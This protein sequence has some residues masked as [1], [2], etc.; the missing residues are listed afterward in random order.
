MERVVKCLPSLKELCSFNGL[1][2]LKNYGG[3]FQTFQS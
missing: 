2:G 1:N 3:S